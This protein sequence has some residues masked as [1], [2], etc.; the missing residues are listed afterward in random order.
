MSNQIRLKRG[1]GSN[2]SASDLVVGEVALR[3]DNGKLFTKK[4]DNSITE[5]GSGISDGDKGDITISNS[6]GTFTIDNGA[7]TSAKILD[8]TI[9]GS[10]L[11]TNIDLVDNQKLRLGTGNDLQIYHDGSH[12]YALNT[13]GNLFL[14]SNSSVDIGDGDFTE[15]AARFNHDGAVELYFD[16]S[17]KFETTNAG[18]AV[19]GVLTTSSYISIG[20]SQHLYLEDNG[21][22]IFGA[23]SDLQIYHSGTQSYVTDQGTGNLNLQGTSKVVIGNAAHDE[24]MAQF[25]AD[26]QVELYYDNSKKFET[27]SNGVTLNDGLLLDNATNAGRDVQWQPANDRLAFLNNTKA[28]FGNGADLQIY[29]D[30]NSRI[31]DSGNGYLNLITNGSGI[32]L[33]KSDGESLATFLTDGSVELFENGVKKFETTSTGINVTNDITNTSGSDLVINSTGR[34]QLQVANGE[35]AVYCDNNGAVELYFNNSKKFETTSSGATVTGDLTATN[36]FIITG[37]GEYYGFD[38]SKIVLGHGR[39]LQ[40]YHDGSDSYIYQN[41]TGQLKLNTATFRVMDRNGGET[42]LLAT[43]NGAVE[44]YYDNSGPKLATT[45]TGVNLGG[46]NCTF[47][48]NGKISLGTGSDL[49][50]YHDG[51]NSFIKDSGTGKLKVITNNLEVLNAANDEYLIY[52]IENGAVELY[53]D[54]VKRLETTAS[55]V[56]IP[57]GQY[58]QIKH[59]TGRLTLGAGD[60]LQIYHD[61]TY[62]RFESGA[63]TV[64]FR[65]NL[66]EFGDN[67]GNKYIKC[68][69]GGATELYYDGS[70][71]F[72]TTSSG[73]T[74]TGKFGIGTTSPDQTL[75]VHKGSAGSVSSA[76]SSVLTLES[77]ATAVLQFLTPSAEAAQLRFGDPSDNGAGFIQYNHVDNALQ[78]GTNGPEKM[79]LDASGRLGIGTA[80]PS[81]TLDIEATTP[82]I[83]LTDSDAS[84]T[85]ESEIRGGGGD[86]VLSADRDNEKSDTIIGFNIDG[87]EQMRIDSS[88]DV[89]IGTTNTT[90]KFTVVNDTI[91]QVGQFLA[92]STSYDETVLQAACS[93]NVT[94]GSYNHF[95]CS[96]N[97]VADKMRVRDSGNV[98]NTNNSYGSLSDERL[99][100]NIVD[101]TSQWNDIKNIRVRK[102]N[103]KEGV[104]PSKPTL[105]GV[106]AQEAELVCPNL[107]ETDVQLQAGEEK[108]YK[109]FKYSVLYMKAIKCLQEAMAKIEVLETEVAALKAG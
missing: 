97:G 87:S 46:G 42:Q 15:Y 84:G 34:V 53:F 11:A 39:D 107:I 25:F 74:V 6:G 101:A 1:S 32:Y 102:F 26:G 104:D 61:G 77:D 4:D 10:D 66:I 12:G 73:A 57:G 55:G 9:V 18:V 64:L 62:N 96:I 78:F 47:N 69:D 56:N 49:Q 23:G 19:S 5:I 67:S 21:K 100:E 13:T 59:D 90:H 28:T 75:H 37:S 36:D 91:Q 50:I 81:V 105:L 71:K 79:R 22:A 76:P 8:G 106:I 89:S 31:F 65:S 27:A 103:F 35:K 29:Y 14:G 63:T 95:K 16:N 30:G 51:S 33:N 80:S 41:G 17:K 58:L 20:G 88:G 7:V 68:I 60:D 43:E 48:D 94:N 40:I 98:Q 108:E 83:R 85:P 44:L 70:K 2:P 24:N 93:R 72:E 99:K 109:S 45:A 38:N 3:T 54:S 92:G 82:T 52:A 86:L